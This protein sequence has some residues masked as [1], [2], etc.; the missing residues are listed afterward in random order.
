MDKH[1]TTYSQT[2]N[3]IQSTGALSTRPF[4][5]TLITDDEFFV[6]MTVFTVLNATLS[7]SGMVA[8]TI[9]I[10]TFRKLDAR[11]NF[12]M[13]FLVLSSVDFL[14]SLSAFMQ[15]V[16]MTF[17]ILEI[18]SHNKIVFPIEPRAMSVVF[19]NIRSCLINAPVL[20]TLYLSISKCLCVVKPLQFKKMFSFKRNAGI[21]MGICT[22]A[23]VSYIPVYAS[24][25]VI[26]Q[27]D[28]TVN[29][30]RPILWL[31]PYRDVIR[32]VLWIIR[33][34]FPSM[35]SEVIIII[36][37]KFMSKALREAAKFRAS[38]K[39]IISESSKGKAKKRVN[40]KS[41][42]TLSFS[43]LQLMKQVIAVALIF[44]AGNTPK[45]F[46]FT[47]LAV[48]PDLNFGNRYQNLY[49]V[50]MASREVI[51]NLISAANFIVYYK[52]NS[53]YTK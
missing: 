51:E 19:A 12:L 21:L 16:A 33:D 9:N 10:V 15:Q 34:T 48:V 7:M 49:L 8:N 41:E 1:N 28:Q 11:D 20:I 42:N 29:A 22:F 45:V 24:T 2:G 18:V 6:L 53:K 17:W 50:L 46:V 25:W 32:N 39:Q 52:Y 36:C 40:N 31:T 44:I 37:V 26:S 23:L 43:E 47:A 4:T 13:C 35:A 5:D 14:C 27:Y 38:L 3:S 30:T